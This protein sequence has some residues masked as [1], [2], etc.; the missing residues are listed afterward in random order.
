[1]VLSVG[2]GGGGGG[3]GS[4]LT[5]GGVTDQAGGAGGAAGGVTMNS[6]V[7]H[8]GQ[9]FAIVVGAGGT[10][11]T[12][13]AANGGS[14]GRGGVGGV[15]SCAGIASADGGSG[16]A[17][18]PG[19]SD[20]VVLNPVGPGNSSDGTDRAP[21]SG[22]GAGPSGGGVSG[23]AYLYAWPG[24]G[25]GGTATASGGGAEVVPL[26]PV[27]LTLPAVGLAPCRGRPQGMAPPTTS[28]PALLGAEAGAEARPQARGATVAPAS[29][30]SWLSPTRVRWP[31]RDRM[32]EH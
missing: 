25:G 6:F 10:P 20:A 30:G 32:S 12:G 26:E 1:M 9:R 31:G 11:G 14:G 19:N 18:S 23:S 2:G 3:G 29:G 16:A 28:T 27:E 15:S 7:G 21:G 24:G 13:G 22:G 17:G 4:A 5:I 8:V